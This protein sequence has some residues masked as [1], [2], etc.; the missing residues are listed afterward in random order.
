MESAQSNQDRVIAETAEKRNELDGFIY[1]T[2]SAVEGELAPFLTP[3]AVDELQ[4]KLMREEDW[5]NDSMDQEPPVQKSDYVR[6][7]TD[8]RALAEPAQRRR[9]E[10]QQRSGAV[11]TFKS[12]LTKYRLQAS[13][14]EGKNAHIEASEKAK[15]IA[16]V[17]EQEQWLQDA[18]RVGVERLA[19]PILT[20]PVPKP[21]PAP[22]P[23]A[24][25]PAPQPAPAAE[26]AAPAAEPQ[27]AS[28]EPAAN[29]DIALQLHMER[30][31]SA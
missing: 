15:V 26:A 10:K 14:P 3:A 17:D 19:D 20:K 22:A 18:R 28:A 8:L 4:N 11:S 29:M 30:Y 25:A 1:E 9:R 27:A 5:L 16:A 23:A 2:R 7:L 13:S 21:Q 24:A 6:H 31:L 12:T